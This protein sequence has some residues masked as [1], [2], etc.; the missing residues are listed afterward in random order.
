MFASAY[1]ELEEPSDMA[2]SGLVRNLDP[3]EALPRGFGPNRWEIFGV[4]NAT[5]LAL[6]IRT[7]HVEKLISF[8][9]AMQP[10]TACL[11]FIDKLN[12]LID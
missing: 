5:K 9:V 7:S 4:H 1:A 3:L 12:K 10:L 8:R 6:A 11:R 2:M